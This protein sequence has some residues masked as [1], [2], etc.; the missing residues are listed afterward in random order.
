ML[1]RARIGASGF[2]APNTGQDTERNLEVIR[3][4]MLDDSSHLRNGLSGQGTD[5]NPQEVGA[6]G[7][8]TLPPPPPPTTTRRTRTMT[9]AYYY[10]YTHTMSY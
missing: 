7:M 1:V 6:P 10:H 9:I 4:T 2:L 5:R 8:Q 3:A